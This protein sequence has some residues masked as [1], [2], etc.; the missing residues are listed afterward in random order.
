MEEKKLENAEAKPKE[1]SN[2]YNQGTKNA[3][4]VHEYLN[5]ASNWKIIIDKIKE[6]K[7]RDISDEPKAIGNKACFI[8]GSG[9]SIDLNIEYLKDWEGGIIC[10][11]SHALTFMHYGIEPSHILVLD[12]FCRWDELKG[13]D[14]SKTK[15]KL[16]THPGCYPDIFE[17]W[18]NEILLY[19]Q[20]AGR[21]DSFYQEV[22]Q[23]MYS[24]RTGDFRQSTFHYYIR[25]AMTIFA[26]SPPMQ[27]FAGDLLGYEKFYLMGCDF[28]A[29]D[30]KYRFTD[31]T[32]SEEIEK[33][34]EE[35]D[36]ISWIKHEHLMDDEYLN[37]KD[38][39]LTNNGLHTKNIHLYY[40]KNLISAWRLCGRTVY[41]TDKG[42]M[43][44]V[45]F[46]D[47]KAVVKKQGDFP[48]QTKFFINETCDKY[49]AMVGAFVI[50][51]SKG[52]SF[53]ESLNPLDVLP[54]FMKQ[55]MLRYSCDVCH[56]DLTINQVI[57]KLSYND[58]SEDFADGNAMINRYVELKN[59]DKIIPVIDIVN[60]IDMEHE[61]E[62]C[63]VCKKGKIHK[64]VFVDIDKN[65]D[66]I[67]KYL[68]KKE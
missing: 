39:V 35:G 2:L 55:L 1:E 38:L 64:N 34:G 50:E 9:M 52:N 25:T 12:P 7:A 15:T 31:Y 58:K 17:N 5:T 32:I 40:L 36:F 8:I 37:D 67:K 51:T 60:V 59:K 26:C 33:H 57:Y 13:V 16:I 19:L 3:Q 66:R 10:T 41:S 61:N 6:G 20:N 11:T 56:V 46:H 42:A 28:A 30:G 27:L 45:P 24:Y 4:L 44:Q 68:P 18:P 22:Q 47:I 65:M 49:L 14:W 43:T 54:V 62:E 53:I 29:H 63:P 23:K 48:I 21:A